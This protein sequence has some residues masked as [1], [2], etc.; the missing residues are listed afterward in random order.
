MIHAVLFDADGLIIS[1]HPYFSARLHD[2]F[3]VPAEAV[4]PFFKNEFRRCTEGKADLKEELAS[5]LP[6]WGWEKGADELLRVWFSGER[7]VNEALLRTV[8]ALRQKGIGCYL[9]SDNEKYRARYVMEVMGL[10]SRF[11]GAFFSCDLGYTKANPKFYEEVL[12]ELSL[13]PG[14]IMCWDDDARNVSVAKSAGIDAYLYEGMDGFTKRMAE[15][16]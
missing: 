9:A 14:K 4:L 10:K 5:Y 1:P 11:D 15:L 6:K 8:H 13:A 2:E 7:A 3:G 12:K 16:L